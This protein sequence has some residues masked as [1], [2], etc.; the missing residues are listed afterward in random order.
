MACPSAPAPHP[1]HHYTHISGANW[2]CVSL[3]GTRGW[4]DMKDSSERG[5]ACTGRTF[6]TEKPRAENNLLVCTFVACVLWS[7]VS[8]LVFFLVGPSLSSQEC[9]SP[10]CR[11]EWEGHMVSRVRYCASF[12]KALSPA[13]ITQ[14]LAS[15]GCWMWVSHVSLRLPWTEIPGTCLGI[16]RGRNFIPVCSILG[17]LRDSGQT[18]Q[19]NCQ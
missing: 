15:P 12:R 19:G 1:T 4:G 11:Q 17:D 2:L 3:T 5:Y 18:L 13:V 8:S 16:T 7:Q 6:R 14:R 9:V 10:V